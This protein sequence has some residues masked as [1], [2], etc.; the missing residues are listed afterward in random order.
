MGGQNNETDVGL[1]VEYSFL[2]AGGTQHN[3][4]I[5]NY[6]LTF[7]L[8]NAHSTS[9]PSLTL[10]HR[11]EL[12]LYISASTTRRVR[13]ID[14]TRKNASPTE[15]PT[16]QLDLHGPPAKLHHVA[17]ALGEVHARRSLD[18]LRWNATGTQRMEIPSGDERLKGRRP[19]P[20]WLQITALEGQKTTAVLTAQKPRMQLVLQIKSLGVSL[21]MDPATPDTSVPEFTQGSDPQSLGSEYVPVEDILQKKIVLHHFAY[22]RL[23]HVSTEYEVKIPGDHNISAVEHAELSD[24]RLSK[25]P[26][27]TPVRFQRQSEASARDLLPHAGTLGDSDE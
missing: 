7:N 6:S 3:D 2:D 8:N 4:D 11:Y 19:F 24:D 12:R 20:L 27:A 13:A 21:C 15:R 14:E 5:I 10:Q 26:S 25:R 22:H 17:G 9:S 1:P 23:P 16:E 18:R